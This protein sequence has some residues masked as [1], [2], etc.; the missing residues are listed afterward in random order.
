MQSGFPGA[1][2]EMQIQGANKGGVDIGSDAA[3]SWRCITA[4]ISLKYERHRLCSLILPFLM[5][6]L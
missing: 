6:L 2:F 1:P 5:V 4:H 3:K